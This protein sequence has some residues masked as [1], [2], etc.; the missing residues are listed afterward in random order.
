MDWFQTDP[1]QWAATQFGEANLGDKRRTNRLLHLA[2]QVVGN[3]SGSFPN[4]TECWADLKAAYRLF[5]AEE[6]TFQAV[7]TPH[8]H[9]T[10][11]CPPGRYL[12]IGDTTEFDW[13]PGVE[14]LAPTGNGGGHGFLL[15]SALMVAAESETVVGLA[16]QEIHYR[17]P[18]PKGE[19][20]TQRLARERESDLWGKV[21]DAVGPPPEAVQW[22]HVLDRGGDH[23][24][25][26]CHCLEQ[27][28]DWVVRAKS[29]H[30][31][32]LDPTGREVTVA[33]YLETLPVAGTFQ[34]KLRA[35]PKQ[36]ARIA[37]LAVSFG[38][39][40]LLPPRLKSPYLKRLCPSPISMWVVRV[41]EVDPRPGVEPI[42][43]VLYTSLPVETFE[44]AM[45]VVGYYEK[46]WLIEEWHKALKAVARSEPDRPAEELVPRGYIRLLNG[47]SEAWLRRSMGAGN[48]G[49]GIAIPVSEHD[50]YG[51]PV[52]RPGAPG[53]GDATRQGITGSR[54]RP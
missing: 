53:C 40:R 6:V 42:E 16:G 31:K 11:A 13:G 50:S 8:W 12:V 36:P 29:L 2:K 52:K 15:H 51:C 17:K 38:P 21:I 46:R 25:V 19:T 45:V 54:A 35:R 41:R 30:R 24:E 1:K 14:G 34:L 3:P 5:D 49:S 44:Q 27:K 37:H 32:M 18:V 22:V 47:F 9:R 20:R 28:S 48:A 4:I 43:W 23:F 39:L 10:R 7:A 26:Y 33:E